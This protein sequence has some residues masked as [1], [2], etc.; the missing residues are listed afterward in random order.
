MDIN[1]NGVRYITNSDVFMGQLAWNK[2]N[3]LLSTTPYFTPI[4]TDAKFDPVY[5]VWR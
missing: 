5:I 1:L 4:G 2:S 3:T